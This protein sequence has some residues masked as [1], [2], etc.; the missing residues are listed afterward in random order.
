MEWLIIQPTEIYLASLLQM[1]D[2]VEELWF[3]CFPL[4]IDQPFT[5]STLSRGLK[6]NS[7]LY[8]SHSVG[9]KEYQHF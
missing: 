9:I 1:H 5:S 4:T 7:H 6:Q 3:K 8:L 2:T